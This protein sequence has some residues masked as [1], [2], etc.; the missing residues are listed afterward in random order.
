M[1][2][3][4]LG[5]RDLVTGPPRYVPSSPWWWW[6]AIVLVAVAILAQ[7]AGMLIAV[8]AMA[9]AEPWIGSIS[10]SG[11]A[12]SSL[13]TPAGL[14]V[15]IVGQLTS[16]AIIWL[17][18]DFRGMRAS[19]L[20]LRPPYPGVLVCLVAGLVVLAVTNTAEIALHWINGTDVF[21]DSRA[22]ASGLLS[23]LWW[24]TLIVAV[25]L[26]PLWEELAFRGFLLSALAP[27]RLGFW[28]AAL[29]SNTA[30]TGLHWGYAWAGLGA[31]FLGGMLISWLLWRTGS[32]WIAIVTHALVNVVAVIFAYYWVGAG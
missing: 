7:T 19:V 16:L 22:L 28:G 20:R 25:I 10:L 14:C 4:V 21:S 6:A 32:I 13:A 12:L 9:A 2:A 17:A 31:V 29:V 15:L 30:W 3:G 8:T 26:A 23:P 11:E 1:T 5:L 27:T 18:A 24:G